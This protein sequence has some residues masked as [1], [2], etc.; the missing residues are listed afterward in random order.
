MTK[1]KESWGWVAGYYWYLHVN[2]TTNMSSHSS[3]GSSHIWHGPLGHMEPFKKELG[4][5]C[6]FFPKEYLT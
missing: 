4:A 2:E 1:M 5:E 3:P 6:F